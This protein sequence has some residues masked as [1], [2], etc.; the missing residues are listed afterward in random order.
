MLRANRP[1]PASRFLP[2]QAGKDMCHLR[3]RIVPLWPGKSVRTVL[4]FGKRRGLRIRRMVGQCIDAGSTHP[5]VGDRIRMHRDEQRSTALLR[6][7]HPLFQRDEDIA[8]AGKLH[9]ILACCLQLPPQFKRG[10]Q[11]DLL[12]VGAGY[13]DGA[14]ILAAVPGVQHHN[15]QGC[16][17][18]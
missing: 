1:E 14:R 3:R 16:L 8:R 15:R 4:A 18:R 10:G 7:C 17:H 2:N 9:P 12:F 11:R 5:T 13:T 6:L